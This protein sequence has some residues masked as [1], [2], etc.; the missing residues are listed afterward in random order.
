M[1]DDDELL[2]KYY[3]R[4]QSLEIGEEERLEGGLGRQIVG[5]SEQ[6]GRVPSQKNIGIPE[7]PIKLLLTENRH[8][9]EEAGVHLMAQR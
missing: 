4:S 3:R 2:Q 7:F 5:R 1:A 9:R 6:Q 8:E